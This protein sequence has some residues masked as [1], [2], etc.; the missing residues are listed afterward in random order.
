MNSAKQFWRG[1]CGAVLAVALRR[2]VGE[3]PARLVLLLRNG[4][5]RPLGAGALGGPVAEPAL[6]RL[7]HRGPVAAGAGGDG[8]GGQGAQLG[9]GPDGAV[10]ARAGGHVGEGA[11]GLPAWKMSNTI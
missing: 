7:L 4:K 11:A 3:P 6:P 1:E 10:T 2:L 8:G 5:R 9:R